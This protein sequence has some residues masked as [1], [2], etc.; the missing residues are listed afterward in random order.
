M[1]GRQFFI[2]FDEKSQKYKIK[3]L[4]E[5]FGVFWKV[6]KDHPIKDEEI[7]VIGKLFIQFKLDLDTNA[8]TLQFIG[9][10][11]GECEITP[12]QCKDFTIGTSKD[13]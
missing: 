1:L 7:F 13:N 6:D 12:D 5:E 4:G 9:A 3:D 2:K 10:I 8:L 11:S